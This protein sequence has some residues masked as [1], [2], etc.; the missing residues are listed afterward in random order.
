MSGAQPDFT[1][2]R[3]YACD[4]QLDLRVE[5]PP[6]FQMSPLN[7]FQRAHPVRWVSPK[8]NSRVAWKIVVQTNA[9]FKVSA[10]RASLVITWFSSTPDASRAHQNRLATAEQS[11][12]A[13]DAQGARW[14]SEGDA[15]V[16]ENLKRGMENALSAR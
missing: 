2:R 6:L 4:V 14:D 8:E 16:P 11:P 9:C 13:L 15:F 3:I 12:H 7:V 5:S 1:S 10:R